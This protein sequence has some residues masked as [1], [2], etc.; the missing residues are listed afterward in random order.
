MVVTGTGPSARHRPWSLSLRGRGSRTAGTA[1]GLQP[2]PRLLLL[3][4]L[5]RAPKIPCGSREE[6]GPFPGHPPGLP[7][8]RT[9]CSVTFRLS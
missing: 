5:P 7:L 4:H 1:C 8:V 2:L 9:P 3:P 6:G